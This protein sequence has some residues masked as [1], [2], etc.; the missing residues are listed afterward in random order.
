MKVFPN[1]KATI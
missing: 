1:E